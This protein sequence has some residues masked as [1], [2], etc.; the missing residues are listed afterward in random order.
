MD[1]KIHTLTKCCFVNVRLSLIISRHS[2]SDEHGSNAIEGQA[3]FGPVSEKQ[4][5]VTVEEALVIVKWI[6]ERAQ[7]E[8]NTH[9]P[10]KIHAGAIWVRL[11]GQVYLAEEDFGWAA[12]VL[13]EL[14][15]RVLKGEGR[16]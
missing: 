6:M 11:S 16:S 10:A 8:F 14:C 13:K 12:R 3:P 15:E 5:E 9:I 4:G 1:N 7:K 2:S